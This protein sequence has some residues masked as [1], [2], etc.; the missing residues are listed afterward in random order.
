MSEERR[1][2]DYSQTKNIDT[3]TQSQV[4]YTVNKGSECQ[5]G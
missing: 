1:Q 3:Q 2:N 5:G 4:Q